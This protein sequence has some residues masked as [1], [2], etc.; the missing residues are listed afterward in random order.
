MSSKKETLT[1]SLASGTKAKLEEIARELGFFWGK[2]PSPSALVNA[3]AKGEIATGQP[4]YLNEQQVKTLR[5][6]IRVLIDTGYVTEAETIARLIL[7][8][9]KLKPSLRQELVELVNTH[10]DKW[11][12]VVNE[13]IKNKQPFEIFYTNSQKQQ[14]IFNVHFAQ[15]NFFEKHFYLHIWCNETNDISENDK[16]YFPEL[17]H[18]RCLRFDRIQGIIPKSEEWRESLDYIQVHLHFTGWMIKAYQPREDD[19]EDVVDG[20]SRKVIRKV[21]NPFWL[22]REVKGYGTNCE[23]IAPQ[24]LRNYYRQELIKMCQQYDL[25]MDNG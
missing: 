7:D 13:H 16:K 11:R 6:A 15:I 4:F 20:E 10:L 5:Q 1:L 23:I 3:I 21:F 24:G 25:S 14:L 22:V 17:I 9:G 2:S 12:L 18:N 19:L 8:K